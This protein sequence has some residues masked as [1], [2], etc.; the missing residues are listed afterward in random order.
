MKKLLFVLVITGILGS[1]GGHFALRAAHDH[2]EPRDRQVAPTYVGDLL[3][4]NGVVESRHPEVAVRPEVTGIIAALHFRENQDVSK[5]A[6]LVELHNAAQKQQLSLAEADLALAKAQ[7]ERLRNG[8]RAEK[9][10]AVAAI[11]Q[12]RAAALHK[13][14]NDFE[15]TQKLTSTAAGSREQFDRDYFAYLQAQAAMAQ[16]QAE[17][18]LIEA[19]ARAE[20]AAAAEASVAAAEAR[21]RLAQAELAKTRLCAPSDGRVLQVFAEPGELASPT[22]A[23]PILLLADLSKRRVRAFVEELDACR[24]KS[25]QAAT[26]TADGLTGKE[27]KGRLAVVMA[28]MGKRAPESDVPGEYKDVYFREVLIDLE[29]GEE[30]P[31]NLRVLAQIRIAP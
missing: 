6:L 25:G 12:A 11:E 7:L 9:R 5:G 15:R 31:L 3:T 14:R 28:R 19:P 24:V 4:A 21:V 16:A 2:P 30:L 20:D 13:A 18:E 27:F 23:H 10:K 22:S 8:E 17:R 26:V 1:A 29:G